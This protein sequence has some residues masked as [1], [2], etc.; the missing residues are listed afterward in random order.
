MSKRL[1][2]VIAAAAAQ[3]V[4]VDVARPDAIAPTLIQPRRANV[5]V[6]RGNLPAEIAEAAA[7]RLFL[8]RWADAVASFEVAAA[9][10]WAEPDA[11][12]YGMLKKSG[13]APTGAS[14][15]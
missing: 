12:P 1:Q 7:L 3:C 5:E 10:A 11:D 15:N 4:S 2:G 8:Q 9:R 14:L 13:P 6:E